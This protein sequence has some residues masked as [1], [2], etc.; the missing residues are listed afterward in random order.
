MADVTIVAATDDAAVVEVVIVAA[1]AVVVVTVACRKVPRSVND[2][3]FSN[4]AGQGI[5]L[6]E[7]PTITSRD[8]G[9]E[10]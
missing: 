4:F 9:S 2:V 7:G 3:C 5:G 1:L 8:Q 6:K 10:P